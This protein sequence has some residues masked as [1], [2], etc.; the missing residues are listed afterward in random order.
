MAITFQKRIKKQKN[1]VYILL[2]LVLITIFI[3]WRGQ[4]LIKEIPVEESI[5]RFKEIKVDFGIFENP[6]FKELQA[7]EKIPS[8]Q[9]DIGRENPFT[10]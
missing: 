5:T 2:A 4:D 1:L 3:I 9:G 6:F 8:F 10:P 7:I